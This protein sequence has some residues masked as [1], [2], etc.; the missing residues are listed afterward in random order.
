LEHVLS[1]MELCLSVAPR[2]PDVDADLLV[3]GA[4]VHDIGKVHELTYQPDLGYSDAGQLIG[5]IVQG[6]QI[7]DRKIGECNLQSDEPIPAIMADRLR[8]MIVSH[9]GQHEFGSPKVPMTLEA[10]VLHHLDNLDSKVHCAQQMIEEDANSDS[11]WTLF[12]PGFG[13]KIYKGH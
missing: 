12:N 6:I 7:L 3:M 11:V 8:H 9:H 1:M 4:F 10:I 13:R 5:H 2:Y